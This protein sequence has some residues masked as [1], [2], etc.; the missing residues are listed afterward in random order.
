MIDR[1]IGKNGAAINK[2]AG[3]AAEDA[4][5]VRAD[6]MVAHDEVAV[7]GDAHGA[8]VAHVFVLRRHVRLVNGAAVDVNDALANLDIFTGQ[9]DNAFDERFRMVERIPENDNVASLDWLE[10]INKFVDEDT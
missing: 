1:P 6:A 3:D 9:A 10:A 5:V 2:L 4:R 8:V 7:P